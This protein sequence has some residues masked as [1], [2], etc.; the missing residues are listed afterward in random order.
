MLGAVGPDFA[1]PVIPLVPD[2]DPSRN[3]KNFER[4]R[5]EQESRGAGREAVLD[6]IELVASAKIR[7]RRETV[8]VE[9]L[10]RP[11]LHRRRIF[12]EGIAVFRCAVS[13][14]DSREVRER[15]S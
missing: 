7:V 9:E 10:L 12:R 15:A 14:P 13:L 11:W 4:V 2:N 1:Y 6:G 5:T 8:V 3:L